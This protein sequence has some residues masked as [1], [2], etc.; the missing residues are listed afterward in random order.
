MGWPKAQGRKN[1]APLPRKVTDAP[2]H[3]PPIRS[4]R[5]CVAHRK[6]GRGVARPFLKFPQARRKKR[7]HSADCEQAVRFLKSDQVLQ[8]PTLGFVF[9]INVNGPVPDAWFRL[10]E[11]RRGAKPSRARNSP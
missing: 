1:R 6:S 10:D 9:L 11:K 3:P 7:S 5:D 2:L 8:Q 4:R